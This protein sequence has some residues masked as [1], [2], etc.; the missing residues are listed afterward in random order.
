MVIGIQGVSGSFHEVAAK[1]Y[2]GSD[3][4]IEECLLFSSLCQKVADGTVDH[5]VM[6]IENTI[7]GSLLG[8]Y[9]LI[10][11]FDLKVVGEVFTR[12]DMNLLALPGTKL[13]DIHTIHSHPIAI[14]QCT[15]FLL[16]LENRTIQEQKDTA[17]SAQMIANGKMQG[18]GAIASARCAEL[19]G[20]E[21]VERGVQ[22]NKENFTRF[23]VLDKEAN[24]SNENDKAS[25]CIQLGHQIGSL[26]SVLN[27]F[28]ENRINLTNLQSVPL[29]GKPS[30]YYFHLDIEWDDYSNYQ[31]A[32]RMVKTNAAE[33]TLLGEYKRSGFN[34]ASA[35]AN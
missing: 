23:L 16:A 10:K 8:N 32:I 6:A 34:K 12:I 18:H 2:F 1:K 33:Y 24:I 27:I 28:N 5:C 26:A 29:V 25:I 20:L 21:L 17:G 9:G 19:F 15:E 4:L 11:Q 13:G 3:I 14:A 30:Q 22:T 31:N 7:A 35:H